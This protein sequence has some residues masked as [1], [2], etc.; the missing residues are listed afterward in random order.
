MTGFIVLSL[1]LGAFRMAPMVLFLIQ[2]RGK[3]WSPIALLLRG[4]AFMAFLQ[5]LSAYVFIASDPDLFRLNFSPVILWFSTIL[6]IGNTILAW[7]L[8][9]IFRRM[10]K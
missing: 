3:F 7:A 8:Y 6:G 10:R 5:A 9:I 4:F 2:Y 1:V